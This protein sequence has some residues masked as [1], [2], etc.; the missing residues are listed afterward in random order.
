[1]TV[2]DDTLIR[3]LPLRTRV[4]EALMRGRGPTLPG[5]NRNRTFGEARTLSDEVL[6]ATDNFGHT[7]L[8][9]W[10]TFRD[11]ALGLTPSYS[12]ISRRARLHSLLLAHESAAIA[13]YDIQR[14]DADPDDFADIDRAASIT[15][16]QEALAS[17]REKILNQLIVEHSNYD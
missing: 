7:S 15:K 14:A 6:L 11:R 5:Y 16:R 8:E 2:T 1:M 13:L 12:R 4:K 9:E 10:V 17:V 3:D